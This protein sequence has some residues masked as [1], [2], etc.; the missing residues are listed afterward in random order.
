MIMQC[1]SPLRGAFQPKDPNTTDIHTIH[2]T[3]LKSKCMCTENV[4]NSLHNRKSSYVSCFSGWVPVPQY[5][6][7][8]QLHARLSTLQT[9][10]EQRRLPARITT[11]LK[12]KISMSTFIILDVHHILKKNTVKKIKCAN[13]DYA[14]TKEHPKMILHTTFCWHIFI[15]LYPE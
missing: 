5:P 14:K 4:S 15:V 9:E 11:L 8:Y 2:F 7:R 13:T 1:K 3:S 12:Q 6:F 10:E